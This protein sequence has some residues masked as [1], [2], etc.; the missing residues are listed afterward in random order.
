MR[1]RTVASEVPAT[2]R[3]SALSTSSKERS[4]AAAVRLSP[5][6]M[7]SG[8]KKP[9]HSRQPGT[10]NALVSQPSRRKSPSGSV[11]LRVLLAWTSG[12]V[13]H[14]ATAGMWLFALRIS[15]CSSLRGRCACVKCCQVCPRG[16]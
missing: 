13:L 9:P 10:L 5:K 1:L 16:P 14:V 7:T 15:S 3:A 4:R 11:V 2:R 12:G 8:L 6:K